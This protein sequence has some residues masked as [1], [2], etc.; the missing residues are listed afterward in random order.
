MNEKKNT[1]IAEGNDNDV[2]YFT[3]RPEESMGFL[4]APRDDVDAG[5]NQL[6]LAVNASGGSDTL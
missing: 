5:I 3:M 4:Q 1:A 2:S 6:N